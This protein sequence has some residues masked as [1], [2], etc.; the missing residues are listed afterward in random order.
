MLRFFVAG[1]IA[2]LSL[3][4]TTPADTGRPPKTL[5]L[6]WSSGGP[7]TGI[8]ADDATGRIFALDPH[9]SCVEIDFDGKTVRTIRLPGAGG[10]KLRLAKFGPGQDVAFVPFRV[11]G[12]RDLSVYDSAGKELWTHPTG[13]GI[14]DVWAGDLDGNGEDEVIVGYNGKTGVHVVDKAGKIRWTSTAVGDVWSVCAGHVSDDGRLQLV[15]SAYD[16]KVHV[17]G[18]D[19]TPREI[20][21]PGCWSQMN[22]IVEPSASPRQATIVVACHPSGRNATINAITGDG[23][24]RWSLTLPGDAE[25]EVETASLAPGRPWIAIGNGSGSTYVLDTG[26]GAILASLSDQEYVSELAWAAKAGNPSPLLLVATGREVN[27][28]RMNP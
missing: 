25:P 5:D 4:A 27:A 7:W 14:D 22:R 11:W 15:T 24:K 6:V 10:T 17:F 18:R 20:L 16:G 12:N 21:D 19:G 23:A 8:A 2:L 26:S 1:A 13:A 9:G 3:S 28:Y